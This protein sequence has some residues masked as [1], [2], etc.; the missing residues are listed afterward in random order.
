MI[1]SYGMGQRSTASSNGCNCINFVW[2]PCKMQ[3]QK[4]IDHYKFLLFFF[5]LKIVRGKR[6]KGIQQFVL[7]TFSIVRFHIYFFY[8]PFVLTDYIYFF[9][10]TDY[11]KIL[12]GVELCT[13]LNSGRTPT[14][15]RRII[16]RIS[17]YFKH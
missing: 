6:I 5:S 2:M 13:K 7:V 10:H 16:I 4:A 3:S 1:A 8:T 14:F 15:F 12:D 11:N 17:L 9:S